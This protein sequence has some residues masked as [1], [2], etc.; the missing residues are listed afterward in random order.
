MAKENTKTD[1][2]FTSINENKVEK[3]TRNSAALAAVIDRAKK[4]EFDVDIDCARGMDLLKVNE[5]FSIHKIFDLATGEDKYKLYKEVLYVDDPG[6]YYYE[7]VGDG[8]VYRRIAAQKEHGDK[9]WADKVAK[10]L[11]IKVISDDGVSES[12]EDAAA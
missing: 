4:G 12:T 1:D 2:K 6:K 9:K 10:K 3:S 8:T 5:I 11:G 7:K